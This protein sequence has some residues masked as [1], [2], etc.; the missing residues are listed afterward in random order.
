GLNG[1][2][3]EFLSLVGMFRR[4]YVFAVLG[5]SG[6]ILGAWYLLTMIQHAFFGPLREPAHSEHPMLDMK[7]REIVAIAPI[8]AICLWIGVMPQ[9]IL[10]AI[11]PDVDAVI[12]AYSKPMA[13]E[14][15]VVDKGEDPLEVQH[16][17]EAVGTP[18][19]VD[20]RD[21]RPEWGRLVVCQQPA[22]Q[23]K[24][25][26]HDVPPRSDYRLKMVKN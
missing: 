24:S 1:F 20:G 10:R 22:R 21:K 16:G 9:P 14:Q 13:A 18:R 26:P 4:N 15:R 5:T 17:I 12:S 19:V 11:R 3:G 23:T 7:L 6:V 2:I 8:C 25:L